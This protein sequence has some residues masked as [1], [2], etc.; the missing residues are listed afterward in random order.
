MT[1]PKEAAILVLYIYT[2]FLVVAL[3]RREVLFLAHAD[4]YNLNKAL[5]AEV[6]APIGHDATQIVA[7]EERLIA[8]NVELEGHFFEIIT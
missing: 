1:A 5:F 8:E 3:H 2:K 4:H 6:V 7:F